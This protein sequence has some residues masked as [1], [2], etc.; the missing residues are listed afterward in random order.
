MTNEPIDASP[1]AVREAFTKL[2]SMNAEFCAMP[3]EFV[4]TALTAMIDLAIAEETIEQ[5]RRQSEA[6]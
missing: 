2:L 1:A 5:L 6:K 4:E 3:R